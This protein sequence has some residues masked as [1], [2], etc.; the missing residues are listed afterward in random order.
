MIVIALSMLL[1]AA[2]S[3]A[4]AASAVAGPSL[5]GEQE[6]ASGFDEAFD[7]ISGRGPNGFDACLP[8]GNADA[9]LSNVNEQIRM[10]RQLLEAEERQ[11]ELSPRMAAARELLAD[12]SEMKLARYF[13]QTIGEEA[14]RP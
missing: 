4:A 11:R 1:Q 7:R 8:A 5:S 9:H 10:V 13:V 2:P 12:D 6:A 3:R 14:C